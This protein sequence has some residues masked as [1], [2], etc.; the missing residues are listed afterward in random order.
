[1]ENAQTQ[2]IWKML[3]GQYIGYT[4]IIYRAS[5]L[6]FPKSENIKNFNR[7]IYNFIWNKRDRI[8]RNAIIGSI[9][10][11]GIGIVD[12]ETKMHAL[13]ESWV[14]RICQFKTTPM[15]LLTVFVQRTT[16]V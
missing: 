7:L 1:M 8:K 6:T 9:D 13:T 16:L 3:C 5:I 11:G 12:I 2:F 10:N 14:S 15:I 4:E